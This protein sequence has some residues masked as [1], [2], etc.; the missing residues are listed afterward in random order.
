[1]WYNHVIPIWYNMIFW[2]NI[3][4]AYLHTTVDGNK[5]FGGYLSVDGEKSFKIGDDMTYELS[6]GHHSLVVYSTSEMQRKAG[7]FQASVYAN[8]RSSGAILD[9]ME[10][11][12]ALK[13][14]GDGWE[15][16]VMVQDDQLLSLN[17]LSK[18]EKIVS[19]PLYN[20]V[21]LSQEEIEQL[22]K[23]FKEWRN[24]PIRS[25]KKMLWGVII[26][27]AGVFGFSNSLNAAD[28]EG[29]FF[30]VGL[31]AIGVL[32]FVLGFRKKI[33]R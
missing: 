13:N 23:R 9:S 17:V 12:S 32:V 19:A 1:M 18:G 30:G 16:N 3:M 24:T 8:T 33:R 11:N 31:A 10:L 14:I 7:K 27:F 4:A 29:L 26:A 15:I 25:K 22:E 21:D 28:T 20:T 5:N 2:R 6:P